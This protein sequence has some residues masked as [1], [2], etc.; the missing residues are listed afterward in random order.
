MTREIIFRAWDKEDKTWSGGWGGREFARM[1]PEWRA[2]PDRY[3]F[4]QYTGLKDKNGKM[5]FEG[6]ILK[7]QIDSGVGSSYEDMGQ[8][9]FHPEAA[10]FVI[11]KDELMTNIGHL[12]EVIGDIYNN[13][14]LLN[15]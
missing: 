11:T 15:D 13:P 6:D 9:I 7:I 2:D 1:C 4:L 12:V 10:Q 3:I 8:V 5:I 14:E